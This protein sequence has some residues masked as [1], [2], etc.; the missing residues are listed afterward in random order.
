MD[1]MK[2]LAVAL[3]VALALAGAACSTALSTMQPADTLPQGGW[4]VGAGMNVDIPAS[5]IIDAIDTAK[6]LGD[7]YADDP[8][9]VPTEEEKQQ[10]YDAAIGLALNQPGVTTDLMLRYGI[11]DRFDAGLRWTTTGIHLDGKFQFLAQDIHGWDGAISVGVGRHAF[12]GLLFDIL[13]YLQVDDFSRY[14]VAVPL[15]FGKRLQEWGR[16]WGGLKYDIAFVSI[17]AKLQNVDETLQV[18]DKVHYF[19]GFAGFGLG[20]RWVHLFAE[21]TVMNMWASPVILGRERDIGG[22]I[23]VPSGGIMGR[24]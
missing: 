24:W 21:L 12:E 3:A 19:G 20:Y 23:V 1:S 18:D 6:D 22:I 8:N 13:E 4:H 17:D 16:F 2:R 11:A 5:R 14:D 10:G 7:R 9:Y 15:I